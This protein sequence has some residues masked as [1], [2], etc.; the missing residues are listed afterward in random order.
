MRLNKN[1][2]SLSIYQNYQ[3]RLK[4]NSHSLKNIS[5][6]I[7][8]NKA[9]D[10]PGKISQ[11]EYLKIQILSNDMAKR[12]IQD[13]NSMIQTFDGAMNEMADTLANSG[14]PSQAPQGYKFWNLVIIN[15]TKI[16]WRF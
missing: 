12:N 10:N 5:S 7:K 3:D 1:M 2:F 8:L 16:K 15:N 11:S 9:K 6:G 4:A 14:K 13:T